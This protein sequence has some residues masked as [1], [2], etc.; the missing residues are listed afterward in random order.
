M[1][2]VTGEIEFYTGSM[3]ETHDLQ[4]KITQ[5][6]EVIHGACGFE[7]KAYGKPEVTIYAGTMLLWVGKPEEMSG[8]LQEAVESRIKSGEWGIEDTDLMDAIAEDAEADL[9]DREH[10]VGL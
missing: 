5:D 2:G 1:A 8:W 4:I 10:A 6:F 3:A 9:F 7:T